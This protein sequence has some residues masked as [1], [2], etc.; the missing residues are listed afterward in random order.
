MFEENIACESICALVGKD[1]FVNC[2][3]KRLSDL[4]AK[5]RHSLHCGVLCVVRVHDAHEVIFGEGLEVEKKVF[6]HEQILV[7][8]AS[9]PSK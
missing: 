1:L 6:D 3:G 4:V 8:L 2:P 7:F 5:V 9:D